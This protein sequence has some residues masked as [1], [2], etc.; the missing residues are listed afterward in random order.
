MI[1]VLPKDGITDP[2]GEAVA[3]VLGRIGFPEVE[4]PR[5]D[6]RMGK[7]LSFQLAT[8]DPQEAKEKFINWIRSDLSMRDFVNPKLHKY[9]V[10][11]KEF[12]EL[13]GD[14]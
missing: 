1:R 14:Q 4:D 6:V 9:E 5:T 13:Q 2:A 10:T 8:D 7:F 11:I 12:Q 3:N